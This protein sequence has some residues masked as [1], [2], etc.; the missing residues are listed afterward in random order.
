MFGSFSKPAQVPAAITCVEFL[1]VLLFSATFTPP[2]PISLSPLSPL[3]WAPLFPV[4]AAS[5]EEPCYASK[6]DPR[7][8][9]YRPM[10]IH[11]KSSFLYMG[12]TKSVLVM[13]IWV[14]YFTMFYSHNM[15]IHMHLWFVASFSWVSDVNICALAFPRWGKYFCLSYFLILPM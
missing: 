7:W 13:W 8:Y 15:L 14:F 5:W 9:F 12:I 6:H 10:F 2:H 4:S 3:F 11:L 1:L